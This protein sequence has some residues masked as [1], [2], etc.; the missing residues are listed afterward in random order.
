M[1]AHRVSSL[2]LLFLVFSAG[3]SCIA[4]SVPAEQA[5]KPDQQQQPECG[6]FAGW[7]KTSSWGGAYEAHGGCLTLGNGSVHVDPPPVDFQITELASLERKKF[8][9]LKGFKFKLKNG[10]KVEFYPAPYKSSG[11]DDAATIEKAIRD[12][13]AQQGVLLK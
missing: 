13:A 3:P 4:Q 1:P 9:G 6:G 7:V 11:P 8:Y 5:P 12:M 2:L 10:K